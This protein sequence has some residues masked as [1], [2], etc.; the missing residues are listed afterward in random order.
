MSLIACGIDF[1][2][3]L[4]YILQP[5]PP[6]SRDIRTL[7]CESFKDIEYRGRK[8]DWVPVISDGKQLNKFICDSIFS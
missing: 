6:R 3:H 4:L 8:R 1:S 7:Q 2:M 5:C